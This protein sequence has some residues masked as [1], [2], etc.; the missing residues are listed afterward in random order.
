MASGKL[1]A[2][3]KTI[4]RMHDKGKN[5]FKT[6]DIR[7][8]AFDILKANDFLKEYLKGWY[9]FCPPGEEDSISTIWNV[10]WKEFV[11]SYCQSRFKNEWYLAPELSL[12]IHSRST[13]SPIQVIVHAKNA[14][15]NVVQL[16]NQKSLMDYRSPSYN[17][18]L[19]MVVDGLRVLTPEAAL[20]QASET[21]FTKYPVDAQVVLAALHDP[22]RLAAMLAEYGKPVVA[23][24]LAGALRAVGKEDA[25][26]II[27]RRMK[28]A[29]Y[30]LIE[31]NPL[32]EMEILP[33]NYHRESP[34]ETRLRL[35]WAC[36]RGDV[37]AVFPPEKGLP[38]DPTQ[39]LINVQEMYKR[40]AYHS[41]SIEGYQVTED[42]IQRV[43]SGE[44]NPHDDS[45][46]RNALAAKGYQMAFDAVKESIRRILSGKNAAVTVQR[47]HQE[48]YY[49]LFAPSIKAGLLTTGDLGGYR[50]GS[51]Y[52]QNSLH[53][54]PN[55][56]DARNGMYAFMELLREEPS[57]PVRVVLGHF[58]FVYIHPYFDG[59][60]RMGRFIMNAL[61]AAGGYPWTIIPVHR[62]DEY[63]TA[64][65]KASIEQDIKPFALFI[66]DCMNKNSDK[67]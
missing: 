49:Q 15:N 51:V 13:M 5:V 54:P 20:I 35:L 56:S 38:S 34:F 9:Y 43:A 48:W 2:A 12:L 59:N 57:A 28:E 23:G 64:L 63:L 55:A 8:D 52:I 42:L 36:M 6:S 10:T 31:T 32:K 47:D 3:L 61:M 60:G 67:E 39:Y 45:N 22:Y 17:G 29:G 53:V 24:R 26:D 50:N 19:A 21:F 41:L 62:R 25:A 16:R 11:A 33:L 7:K 37:I 4:K 30:R 14:S 58:F 44:W 40:D 18:N 1:A 46:T 66:A 65:E 27:V